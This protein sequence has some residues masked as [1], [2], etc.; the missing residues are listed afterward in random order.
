MHS[1]VPVIVNASSGSGCGETEIAKLRGDFEAAG[2]QV[3]IHAARN[4]A[5]LASIAR[6]VAA[7]NPQVIVVGGG[8]GTINCVASAL[9]GTRITLGVVPLGTFNH[10]AKDLHIALDPEA[11]VRVVVAGH[12]ICVD[13]G[14][15]NDRIFLNNS[16]VG[17]YSSFVL[18]RKRQEKRLGRGKWHAMLW[19]TLTVLRR[20]PFMDVRLQLDQAERLHRTPFVFV[21]NN[22]YQMEGLDVG[23]RKRLDGGSLSVY[24]T[25]R[26]DRAGLIRLFLAALLGRLRQGRD[27]LAETT[28]SLR[29][30]SR[31]RHLLVATDG[32]LTVMQTPLDYRIRPAALRVLVPT[33]EPA[34][35]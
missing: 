33:P 31:H 4:G 5:E 1:P 35:S 11:A 26:Q 28:R 32:E 19:A 29:I 21:G 6:R 8:D 10:F 14:E 9:M 3:R 7:E 15:V 2:V 12:S 24:T 13:E 34:A 17:L 27:F 22:E 30:E 16:S 20:R 18:L 25:Q 23:Q